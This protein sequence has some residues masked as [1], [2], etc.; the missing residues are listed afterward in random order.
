M[1]INKIISGGQT[2]AD[3]GVL[4]ATIAMGIEYGGWIPTGSRL[5][6]LFGTSQ[7]KSLKPVE[8]SDA[9]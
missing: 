1:T 7:A 6:Y 4:D 2:G 5:T 3:Q 9:K 8:R